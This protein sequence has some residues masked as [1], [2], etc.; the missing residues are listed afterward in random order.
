MTRNN[1][2]SSVRPFLLRSCAPTSCARPRTG[3]KVSFSSLIS[4]SDCHILCNYMYLKAK[5]MYLGPYAS[6]CT[7]RTDDEAGTKEGPD[8]LRPPVL[9][10]STWIN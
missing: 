1:K 6:H 4:D 10:G 2:K 7:K 5:G 3:L 8:Q 9:V